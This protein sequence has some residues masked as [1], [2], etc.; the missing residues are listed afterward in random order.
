VTADEP[1]GVLEDRLLAINDEIWGDWNTLVDEKAY[2]PFSHAGKAVAMIMY[3]DMQVQNGGFSQWI[4]NPTGMY[5]RETRDA[6]REIGADAVAAMVDQAMLFFPDGCP[7]P[8][9]ET[10]QRQLQELAD[11]ANERLEDLDDGYCDQ[12][13]DLFVTL[14]NYWQEH[15]DTPD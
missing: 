6:L 12:R 7:A 9:W 3:L 14:L 10:R 13:R 8:S 4:G 1:I 2:E 11:V 15:G 5:V